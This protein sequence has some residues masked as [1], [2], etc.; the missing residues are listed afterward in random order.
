MAFDSMSESCLFDLEKY[1]HSNPYRQYS[2]KKSNVSKKIPISAHSQR[3]N[4]QN[5]PSVVAFH[6][7]INNRKNSLTL[8]RIEY[9]LR[10]K[11][12]LNVDT[13]RNTPIRCRRKH[14]DS[15]HHQLQNHT[16]ININQTLNI[17]PS[18]ATTKSYRRQPTAITMTTNSTKTLINDEFN[19]IEGNAV[20]VGTLND[21]IKQ[22]HHEEYRLY[23]RAIEYLDNKSNSIQNNRLINEHTISKPTVLSSER[24]IKQPQA[25][26]VYHFNAPTLPHT[27]LSSQT[28]QYRMK[29][30]LNNIDL[31]L[32]KNQQYRQRSSSLE[33]Q[34]TAMSS[35]DKRIQD[36][37]E[38]ILMHTEKQVCNCNKLTIIDPFISEQQQQQHETIIPLAKQPSARYIFPPVRP[39]GYFTRK[40][41][42]NILPSTPSSIKQ[43]YKIKKNHQ[44]IIKG[45]LESLNQAPS[46]DDDNSQ[47]FNDTIKSMISSSDFDEDLQ[48]PPNIKISFDLKQDK[49]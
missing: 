11:S 26:T 45:S 20:H 10:M 43:K 35:R 49:R 41:I 1:L 23:H 15:L 19:G 12:D 44:K 32:L 42:D 48:N 25:L 17:L 6:Q 8:D 4:Y 18:S 13:L 46:D 36:S 28:Y 40:S 24:I 9:K 16:N 47:L 27:S 31:P 14:Y 3:F 38:K 30:K 33:R 34:S 5:K 21:L 37:R 7:L 39:F 2:M 29:E 22:C